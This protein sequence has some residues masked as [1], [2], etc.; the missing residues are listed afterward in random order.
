M[1][2]FQHLLE[3]LDEGSSFS[4]HPY[5]VKTKGGGKEKFTFIPRSLNTPPRPPPSHILRDPVN[6]SMAIT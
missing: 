5:P 4:I 6:L 3:K 1:Y 2:V